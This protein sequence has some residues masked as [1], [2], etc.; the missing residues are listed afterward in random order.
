MKLKEYIEG[1]LTEKRSK[2]EYQDEINAINI[3]LNNVKSKLSD[4]IDDFTE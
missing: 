2:E 1:N 4:K 3:E